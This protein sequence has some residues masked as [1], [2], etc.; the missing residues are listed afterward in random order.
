MAKLIQIVHLQVHQFTQLDAVLNSVAGVVGVHM[1]LHQLHIAADLHTVANPVQPAAEGVNVPFGHIVPQVANIK[2]SAIQVLR[3][4]HQGMI[5]GCFLIAVLC[6]AGSGIVNVLSPKHC[7]IA[8]VDQQQTT[9][10]GVHHTSLL[11]CRQHVRGALQ[12][13]LAAAQHHGDQSIVIIRG[14]IGLLHRIL[15]HHTSHGQN[16]AF[17]RLHH[18][19]IGKLS[20]LLQCFRKLNR[21]DLF[22][23]GQGLGE[24][25]E[26]LAGDNA[27][28]APS[29]TK[30]TLGQRSSSFI[31]PEIFLAGNFPGGTLHGQGHVGARVA[32]RHRKHVQR[33][34]RFT[35]LLQQCCAGNNH[36]TQQKS[37]YCLKLNQG[38]LP[39]FDHRALCRTAFPVFAPLF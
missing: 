13:R 20:T 2:G 19:L 25:T 8:H 39:P 5:I 29:A 4:P 9:S 33:I 35:I 3:I 26:K 34:H 31:C 27:G 21:R 16:G 22:H 32:I 6:H 10:A 24:A 11:Q 14:S 28:V 12:N 17:L 18:S 30:S 37:V 36:I 15:S 7:S 1:G 38:C 23:T